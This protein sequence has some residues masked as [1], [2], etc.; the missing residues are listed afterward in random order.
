MYICYKKTSINVTFKTILLNNLRN[1]RLHIVNGFPENPDL[2]EHTGL[3]FITLHSV[4]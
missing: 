2:Q 3:W 4:F 1:T